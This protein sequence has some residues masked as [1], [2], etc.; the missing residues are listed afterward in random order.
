MVDFAGWEMP[1]QYTGVIEEHRAV[2]SS[3]GIFDLSHMGE[4]EVTGPG[5][6]RALDAALV[7]EP[8]KLSV[9]R[10]QYSII[11]DGDGGMID[12]LVVYRIEIGRAHV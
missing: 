4:I 12:D 11:V 8:S 3:A 7:S 2:R 6:G 10:A 9:G 5:A 1:V